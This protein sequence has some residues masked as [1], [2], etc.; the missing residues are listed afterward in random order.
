MRPDE[1]AKWLGTTVGNF[2]VLAHRRKWRRTG[3]G[4]E[5]RYWYDDVDAEA[6]RRAGLDE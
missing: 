2:H 1:A 4:R 5:V 3:R 6:T